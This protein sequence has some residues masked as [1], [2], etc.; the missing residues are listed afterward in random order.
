MNTFCS[1]LLTLSCFVSM[2]MIF[3]PTLIAHNSQALPEVT[4]S[5][6]GIAFASEGARSIQT[7][8]TNQRNNLVVSVVLLASVVCVGASFAGALYKSPAGWIVST[9]A[10]LA[11]LCLL[12]VGSH[13]PIVLSDVGKMVKCSLS[14]GNV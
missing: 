10:S 2:V 1:K 11:C 3:L 7:K 6:G 13:M 12:I 9:L 4:M 8:A 14:W 5:V